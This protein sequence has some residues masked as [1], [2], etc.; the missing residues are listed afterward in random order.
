MW[1]P[2]SLEEGIR[3]CGTGI[4]DGYETPCARWESTLVLQK[5]VLTAESPL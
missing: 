3:S 2:Q 1:Y 5:V 4:L